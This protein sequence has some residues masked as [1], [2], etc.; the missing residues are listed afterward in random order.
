M[1]REEITAEHRSRR[2][3]V[4]VRQSTEQ[5][6]LSHRESQRRQ[7]RLSE[8]ALELGWPRELVASV[9]EDLGESASRS[10]TRRGFEG[11]V[12]EA[13]LGKVGLIL[14]L[15][16]SRLS[17]G[18]SDWYHLLDICAVTRTLIA[19][20]DGLYDPRSY[21]DR[22]LLGLKGTMSEAELHVMKGRLVEA[23]RSKARRGEFQLVL[24]PGFVWDEAGRMQL[25][26]D[27]QVRS[28]I[29]LVFERFEQLG[30]IHQVHAT[31]ADEG[32]RMPSHAR[33]GD[34]VR[35]SAPNYGALHR[36]LTHPVYAGAYAY[37]RRQVEEVLDSSTRRPVKR[38]R[39]REREDWHALIRDHHQGYIS[40]EQFERNQR[41]IESNRKGPGPGAPRE[42]EFLLQ[43]LVLCGRCGRR[44]RVRHQG[45][46]GAPRLMCAGARRQTGGPVCQGFGA[47]RLDRAVEQLLL[48]A[49]EPVGLE[50]MLEGASAQV[51]ARESERVRWEQCLERARYEV[52]L[53][54]RQYDA[55]DPANR[56]VARELERRW[57]EALA[58]LEDT[59]LEARERLKELETPLSPQDEARLRGYASQLPSLWSAPTTRPQDRKRIAR[60]LIEHVVV[61]PEGEAKLEVQVHWQGGE[62]TSLSVA[63]GRRGITR[64]VAPEELIELIR[65]LVAEFSD[66]QVA[67]VLNRRGIRTPKGLTWTAQRVAVT[68][69]NHGIGVGPVVPRRGDD[70]YS[71]R[72]AARLLDVDRSTLIRWVQAGVVKGA[73]VSEAAPWRIRLSAQ[74]IERL[75]PSE[76]P[77]GWLSLKKAAQVL[78]LSQQGVL[79]RLRRGDLEGVRVRTGRRTSWRIRLPSTTCGPQAALFADDPPAS[80]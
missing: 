12:A 74:D 71:A 68:R 17:R 38:I 69:N 67:T 62:V 2:A 19:D 29:A 63:R 58:S 31:L 35:W 54:R 45:P 3:L 26:P 1:N 23:M 75:R 36:M 43:G 66:S 37:G 41:Q 4:Y 80:T 40:W 73:Q 60:L 13:A 21:N 52:D 5:Q 59:E 34:R 65:T 49:L 20:A 14:A 27:E 9:D 79:Q 57:E 18:N 28:A 10:S 77:D 76:L 33:S 61:R 24:P 50:A 48:E 30:T 6:V 56:L 16:V 44:M 39:W 51:A 22:L 46:S 42:G 64:H 55:V 32:F 72:Q 25:V 70:V 78:G 8:R 47:R 7:R 53:A 11:L 15:E